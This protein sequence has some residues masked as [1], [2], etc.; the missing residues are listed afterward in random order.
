M[1][2]LPKVAIPK[3]ISQIQIPFRNYVLAA[4]L[5]NVV[6]T[7][8]V[9]LVRRFLPPEVP[10]YYGLAEGEAQLGS[11]WELIIPSLAALAII[12]VN[13]TISRLFKDDFMQKALIISGLAATFLATITV[14]KVVFLVGSF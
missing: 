1:V 11:S 8:A 3:S 5:V 14:L 2:K 10:L 6:V 7:F 4:I 12:L 13:I 9:F